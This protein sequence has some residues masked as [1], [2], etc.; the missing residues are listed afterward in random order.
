MSSIKPLV[1]NDKV[2]QIKVKTPANKS[3]AGLLTGVAVGAY[4][5]NSWRYNQKT[6]DKAVDQL[7]K[8]NMPQKAIEDFKQSALLRKKY[9]IPFFSHTRLSSFAIS[10]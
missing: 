2:E 1:I 3:N 7:I 9:S 6:I 5:A 4:A 8:L 10:N